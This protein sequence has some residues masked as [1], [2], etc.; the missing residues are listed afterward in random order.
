[1]EVYDEDVDSYEELLTKRE[2]INNTFLKSFI[3]Y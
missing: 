3:I 1:M 2:E